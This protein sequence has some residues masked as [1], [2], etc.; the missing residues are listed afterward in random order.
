MYYRNTSSFIYSFSTLKCGCPTWL[1]KRFREA[2]T[3][4]RLD[5]SLSWRVS[6]DP[7]KKPHS[8]DQGPEIHGG[9]SKVSLPVGEGQLDGCLKVWVG[10]PLLSGTQASSDYAQGVI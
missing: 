6:E 3:N 4:G 8:Y 1:F 5:L 2:D 10:G 9:P 7:F